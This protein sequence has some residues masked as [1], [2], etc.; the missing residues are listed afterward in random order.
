MIHFGVTPK[1]R[2]KH[3]GKET[4]VRERHQSPRVQDRGSKWRI[5]YWDYRLGK[6]AGRTKSW[7]KSL[8]P[9]RIQAQRLADQFMQA[10]NEKNN[11]PQHFP[12]GEA[13]LAALV[14]ICR[15]KMW[16]LLKNSTR[17]SYDFHL[18]TY[19]LP[20]WGSTELTKL[21]TIELQDFF[22]SFSPRLA[23]KT[24]R[25]MHACLRAVI[26]QGKAWE[27]VKSNPAQ[28]VRLPRRKA[29]KPPVVLPKQDIRRVIEALPEP[30]KSIVTLIVVGSLRIGEVAALRWERIH[31]DRIDV[32]ERFYE[33]EFDDTKTDA[34]RRSIPFD[35]FGILRGVFEAMW[36]R[37]RNRNP[38]DLV[39]T[40]TKGGPVCRR[41]LLNRQLK[42]TIK[43]LG[44]PPS[45][46][47]RSFRTMHSSLMSSIGVRPEV[48]RDNM[49]HA[50]VD[51]TQN[52]YNRTWW[53]ERVDAVSMA[54]ATV[55]REFLTQPVPATRM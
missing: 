29:R 37:S 53:E 31:P 50:T 38:G 40:N 5:C 49:G 12:G 45:V 35:S 23:S 27:L 20:K 1:P 15:Q 47:F 10:A 43:K 42:P 32:V 14:A 54:A 39:F 21:R 30:T 16:P 19:V 6:R 48:T 28:G 7:A 11:E 33:G 13:T 26:N 3:H 25:N 17:T 4:V 36:Q 24:I 9:T 46:D 22:N 51:V 41:N 52:V 34:G 44:L 55:W 2:L 18:D 8:V